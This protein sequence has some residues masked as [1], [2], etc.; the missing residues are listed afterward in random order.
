MGSPETQLDLPPDYL[1][2]YNGTGLFVASTIYITLSSILLA[3][4]LLARRFT[5]ADRGWDE[6]LLPASWVLFLGL[7]ICVL[8]MCPFAAHLLPTI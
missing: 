8:G 5:E 4:R 7:T 3:L 1:Q 6:F 2:E